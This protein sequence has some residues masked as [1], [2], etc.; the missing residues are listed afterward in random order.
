MYLRRREDSRVKFRRVCSRK[1][2]KT[3]SS[4][5]RLLQNFRPW[6][7]ISKISLCT[8]ELIFVRLTKL[9]QIRNIRKLVALSVFQA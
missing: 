7:G 9:I 1:K 4:E 5:N 6:I 2:K 3:D 8:M